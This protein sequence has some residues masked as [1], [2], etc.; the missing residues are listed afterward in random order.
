MTAEKKGQHLKM[1]KFTRVLIA[2]RGEIA[3]RIIRACREIGLET[4]LAVSE[5][6]RKSLPAKMADRCVVIGPPRPAA[7]YLRIETLIS[8]ALGSGAEAIH[9]GYGF[10]AERPE[11]P[12]ACREKGLVFIGPEPEHIRRMG[13]KIRA[14][15]MA[16]E[17]G[18]PVIPGSRHI[19]SLSAAEKEAD[20]LGYPVLIKAAAGG[21]G[22]GM[23]L[24]PDADHLGPACTEAA[25]E[26][27]EAFGDERL[28][29]EHYVTNARHIEVQ[30][31]GDARGD[32]RHFFE[33]DCSIQR[34]HQ[35]MVEEAP[36]PI[37]TPASRQGLID[38]ALA[39]ARHIHYLSAGTVEFIWDQDLKKFYFL[40]MNTRIQ[41]EHPVTE[42]ITGADLV[43]EQIRIARGE[44]FS[45]PQEE[46]PFAGHA[47]EC[48]I[49]AETPEAGFRPSPGEIQAW[50]APAG[51]HIRL[52]T[53]C[54][55]GYFVPPYYDSLLAKLI[56]KGPSRPEA[57]GAMERALGEFQISGIDTTVSFCRRIM[58]N[59][60]YRRGEIS[61]NWIETAFWPGQANDDGK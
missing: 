38:A 35:K 6:D 20:R 18:V 61:T 29:L 28:Y 5:A 51:Q 13:D 36:C 47:I 10:L 14:R 31:M 44:E 59:D 42:M 52:D 16:Q 40:E 30:V 56:V 34:R 50:K 4:I 49:N 15:R 21:G 2:N 55:A 7:S 39:I 11:F 32:L 48:R 9:P 53:H 43:G 19:E 37:L 26:A 12:E 57:I 54:Y 27:R 24:V 25:A 45:Y 58:Q 23:K 3:L 46:I 33:R 22:R 17:L 8:A 41:V 1:K 60:R